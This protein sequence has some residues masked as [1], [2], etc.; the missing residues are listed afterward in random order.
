MSFAN[1]EPQP[2]APDRSR[3]GDEP[4]AKAAAASAVEPPATLDALWAQLHHAPGRRAPRLGEAL[5]ERGLIDRETLRRTLHQQASTRP[6]RLLGQW[7]VD[8]GELTPAA[9]N[10]ALAQWLGVPVIDPRQLTPQDD[11][12]ARVPAAEAEREGVLPLMVRDE[13]L[14]VAV[15]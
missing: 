4:R 7:L 12:L 11:A 15:P 9:L 1:T 5:I 14:V 3:L 10:Q 8:A 13:T 6:H 2:L